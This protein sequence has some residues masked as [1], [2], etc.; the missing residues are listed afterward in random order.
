MC[1]GD[2]EKDKKNKYIQTF[3]LRVLFFYWVEFKS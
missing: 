1:F 3:Q 2:K